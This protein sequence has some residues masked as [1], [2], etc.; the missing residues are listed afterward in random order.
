MAKFSLHTI[1]SK[2]S[3]K[4]HKDKK[5]SVFVDKMS[6][7]KFIH[8]FREL[9]S[10]IYLAMYNSNPPAIFRK[11]VYTFSRLGDG[12]M[13]LFLAMMVMI[14]RRPIPYMYLMRSIASITICVI[15][16]TYLKNLVN[17]KRPYIKHNLTPIIEPPDRYSFPSG[18]T[19]IASS[20]VVTFGTQ[21]TLILALCVILGLCIATS[22]VFTG[23][24]YPFD[25]FISIFIG[26]SIGMGVNALFHYIYNMPIFNLQDDFLTN[27]MLH[28]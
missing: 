24:H 28:E 1:L 17:R 22:R 19:M 13:W 14:F 9:D 26:M 20:I 3:D 18:H 7:T 4:P 12:Y 5:L 21:S 15:M 23:V 16:F 27:I 2:I 8:G 6:S 11:A 10:K 25:V